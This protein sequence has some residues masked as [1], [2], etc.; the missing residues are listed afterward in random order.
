MTDSIKSLQSD[1]MLIFMAR[2]CV[3]ERA[4]CWVY[5][6]HEDDDED[7][8]APRLFANKLPLGARLIAAVVDIGGNG[9]EAV[10][11]N[12]DCNP[13]RPRLLLMLAALLP[14]LPVLLPRLK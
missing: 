14:W 3:V 6:M 4:C 2:G 9:E 10:L 7:D 1:V 5:V 12:N 11:R 13:V 8:D